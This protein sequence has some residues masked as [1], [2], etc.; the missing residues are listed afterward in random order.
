MTPDILIIH[1][2]TGHRL[3]HGHLHLAIALSHSGQAAVEVQDV[4]TV[5]VS[6]ARNGLVV[7]IDGGRIPLFPG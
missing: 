7:E 3:L 6:R 4:I 2:H 5:V 1:D